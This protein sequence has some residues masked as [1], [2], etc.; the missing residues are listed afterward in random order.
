M[1]PGAPAAGRSVRSRIHLGNRTRPWTLQ[2][3]M[4]E[5]DGGSTG[6][7]RHAILGTSLATGLLVLTATT[8]SADRFGEHP[9]TLWGLVPQGWQAWVM[10]ALVAGTALASYALFLTDPPSRAGHLATVWVAL[11]TAVWV[12]V[13]GQVPPDDHGTGPGRWLTL[14][15]AVALASAHGFRAE[16]LRTFRRAGTG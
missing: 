5:T 12:I 4:A 7:P 2:H 13:V 1:H 15:G 16:E 8:W 9:S 11:L 6:M 3:G 14:L 10:L